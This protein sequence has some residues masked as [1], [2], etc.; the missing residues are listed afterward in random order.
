MG[1]PDGAV[2]AARKDQRVVSL[3]AEVAAYLLVVKGTRIGRRK[4]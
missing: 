4:R 2:A 1:A 3:M